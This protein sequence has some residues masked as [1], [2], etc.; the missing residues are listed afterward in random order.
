M[1]VQNYPIRTQ[2]GIFND[3]EEIAQWLFYKN[4]SSQ[5]AQDYMA[6]ISDASF[7]YTPFTDEC[8]ARYT[9]LK[10]FSTPSFGKDFDELPAWW[11]DILSLIELETNKAIQTKQRQDSGKKINN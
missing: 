5:Y 1:K 8:L 2:I 6:F 9:L 7:I 10:S 4:D 3:H 11:I